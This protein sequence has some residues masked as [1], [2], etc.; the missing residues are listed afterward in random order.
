[1]RE[2]DRAD[3]FLQIEEDEGGESGGMKIVATRP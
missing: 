3:D 2:R 1:V